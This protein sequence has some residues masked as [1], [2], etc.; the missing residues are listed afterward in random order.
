MQNKVNKTIL[1]FSEQ[2]LRI[3]S[4]RWFDQLGV[5][6]VRKAGRVNRKSRAGLEMPEEGSVFKRMCQEPDFVITQM[7]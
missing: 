5:R 3:M 2:V 1:N 7:V 6:A 4:T